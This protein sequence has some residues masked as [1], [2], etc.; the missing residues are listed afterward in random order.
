[1]VS[2]IRIVIAEDHLI[3]RDGI[4]ALISADPHFEVVGEAKNGFEAI[5]IVGKIHTGGY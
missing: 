1:M 2:K 5:Q 4:K 3:V